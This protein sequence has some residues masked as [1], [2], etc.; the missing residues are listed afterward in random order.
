MNHE[1]WQCNIQYA[2]RDTQYE[3]RHTSTS[4]ENP[5]Q[6]DPFYAKQTQ[7]PKKSNECKYLLHKGLQK[8]YPAGRIQKQTQSNP[9]KPNTNPIKPNTNPIWGKGEI[10]AKCVFTKDYEEKC[11]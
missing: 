4:V 8:F 2:I 1:L 9:I 10:D 5:L 3:Q 7:F 6:I 11:G